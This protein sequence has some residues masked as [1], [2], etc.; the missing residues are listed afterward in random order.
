M[1][2]RSR[3]DA[4]KDSG[5]PEAVECNADAESVLLDEEYIRAQVRRMLDSDWTNAELQSVGVTRELAA[6]LGISHPRFGSFTAS[7]TGTDAGRA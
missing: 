6:G 5:V 7:N 2:E 4:I 3:E 1:E